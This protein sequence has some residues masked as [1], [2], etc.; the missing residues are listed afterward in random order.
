MYR[1]I[2]QIYGH[3]TRLPDFRVIGPSEIRLKSDLADSPIY[4]VPKFGWTDLPITL[5][6][7]R[8]INCK[9]SADSKKSGSGTTAFVGIELTTLGSPLPTRHYNL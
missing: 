9:K 7:F 4:I 5:P 8:E 6:D 3:T 1:S 2:F